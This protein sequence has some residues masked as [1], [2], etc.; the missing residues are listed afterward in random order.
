MTTH[1]RK[2]AKLRLTFP[3][4]VFSA[5]LLAF[6]FVGL[7]SSNVYAFDEMFLE[8]VKNANFDAVEQKL[9]QGLS[10]AQKHAIV[11]MVVRGPLNNDRVKIIK[12]LL[13][14]GVDLNKRDNVGRL[15]LNEAIWS[16]DANMLQWL[17][18]HGADPE[19]FAED[20][21]N[22]LHAAAAAGNVDVIKALLMHGAYIDAVDQSGASA[23]LK[24]IIHIE[25]AAATY[26]HA[27]GANVNLKRKGEAAVHFAARLRR[28]EP[29]HALIKWNADLNVKNDEGKTPLLVALEGD[30][31][32]VF[33]IL[34][35]QKSVDINLPD[36]LG[37]S[38]LMHAVEN[39][40]FDYLDLLLM[41]PQIDISFKDSKGKTALIY[42]ARAGNKHAVKTLIEKGA[43]LNTKDQDGKTVLMHASEA[44]KPDIV[45]F[46][47]SKD[48]KVMEK[49]NSGHTVFNHP[50]AQDIE[51]MLT[52]HL[53]QKETQK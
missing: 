30:N 40:K 9:S 50:I 28:L 25:M 23:F 32:A 45:E 34:I 26:L 13:A 41:N 4:H 43:K 44:H 8:Q 47:L 15:I 1:R 3:H 11:L 10:E 33:S 27:K 21:D 6:A 22:A 49:D 17:L 39:Q 29:L 24:S 2:P 53:E 38:P 16:R 12:L 42:A 31:L 51:Q 35:S 20:G 18:R 46:L 5:T 19:L 7:I 52:K 14:Q 48:I 37:V 36:D